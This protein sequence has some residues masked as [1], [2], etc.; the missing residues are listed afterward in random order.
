M[1]PV[2]SS[3]QISLLTSFGSNEQ[4]LTS[5][6]QIVQHFLLLFL[7][8]SKK[9]EK[10]L[11]QIHYLIDQMVINESSKKNYIFEMN[12][13]FAS[14]KFNDWKITIKSTMP[15]NQFLIVKCILERNETKYTKI[16]FSL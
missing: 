2:P 8:F 13:L 1:F 5:T 15:S 6:I 7:L 10:Q 12:L 16:L 14:D 4:T 9:R 11:N 3:V